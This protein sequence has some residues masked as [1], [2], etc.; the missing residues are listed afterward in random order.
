MDRLKPARSK[1]RIKESA[2]KL[3]IRYGAYLLL[4]IS[5]VLTLLF[6]Y[7]DIDRS[8]ANTS[9]S[10]SVAEVVGMVEDDTVTLKP[11]QRFT[12]T[13]TNSAY[14]SNKVSWPCGL[15]TRG[16]GGVGAGDGE[17]IAGYDHFFDEGTPP[18]PCQERINHIYRGA[19]WFDLSKIRSRLPG[20]FVR[21]ALLHFRPVE[22]FVRDSK[23]DPIVG[24]KWCANEL[25][26]ASVDWKKGYTGLPPGA[27]FKS[28]DELAFKSEV[29]C[30]LGGCSIEVGPVVNNWVTGKEGDFGF[31][32]KG[33]DEATATEDK[34]SC[35]TRYGDFELTVN[36]KY[37]TIFPTESP[38]P[39]P[40][41]TP[42][43]TPIGRP[44]PPFPGD[45][46]A[47][48]I[49]S[50]TD[51]AFGLIT[52]TFDTLNGTVS[53]N[54][55]DDVAA[56][57]TISGTVITQPKGTTKDE[58]AKN[59]DSL[60]GYVVEVAK[61][62][63]PAQQQQRSKWVI[64]P[65]TQFIP[66]V[67]KN[68]EGKVVA[69]TQVPLGQGNVIKPK[70]NGDNP[71][72]GGYSTPPLGQA[73]KPVSVNGPFDG[74]FNNTAI[75]LGNNTAEFLA[76]SP[77]KVVVRSPANLI[78]P[79]PIEVNERGRIVAK[80]NYQSIGVR[81]AADKLSLIRGEQTTLTLTLN[82]LDGVTTPVSVQLTNASPGT[83]RMEGG[84]SQVVTA[85]PREFTAGVFT[86]RRTLTGVSA[87]GFNINAVIN[88]NTYS[89][90]GP[91]AWKSCSRAEA[92]GVPYEIRTRVTAV[93]E[94][95][96]IVI[97]RNSAASIALYRTS[98]THAPRRSFPG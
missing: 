97:Q 19:L 11:A 82:G 72:Q 26:V 98:R 69:Q 64:P 89:P 73:G 77:R 86:T 14:P 87:G 92:L 52:T 56:G 8:K 90:N 59:E 33:E 21:N 5:I 35:W 12:F 74:D 78:G 63:N 37:D 76:E 28:L 85:Q 15:S 41:P 9:D 31:I 50:R 88:L 10:P 58:Q 18:L 93:K 45:V 81:L 17:V 94:K 40:T 38:T 36:Y 70:P 13:H 42:T 79:A 1:A 80:C 2:M 30:G 61:Q 24:T 83:I 23:G 43:Y 75:K 51:T 62:E 66:V 29:I 68:R 65:A 7:S 96:P 6:V 95:R 34:A 57:D 46:G 32:I 55:P 3:E 25:L 71:N 39:T 20:V 47:A 54:L 91:G 4:G 84:E 48:Q 22:R 27:P 60:N 44:G 49:S 67:L 53:V 16:I